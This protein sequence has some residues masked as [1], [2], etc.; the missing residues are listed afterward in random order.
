MEDLR[1]PKRVEGDPEARDLL[2]ELIHRS[3]PLWEHADLRVPETD[4]FGRLE[5]VLE[6]AH[7]AGHVIRGLEGA[8][9]VL[10]AEAEGLKKVDEKTGVGRGGRVSRLLVLTQDGAERFYRRVESTLKRHAPRVLAL[11]LEMDEYSLGKKI[12][13]A[14]QRVRLLLVDHKDAVSEV[15]LALADHW[16]RGSEKD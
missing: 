11:R 16:K 4:G 2:N 8:E 3:R 6:K 5:E 10:A 14:D 13:G 15:L 1:L 12:F 9:R 7:A